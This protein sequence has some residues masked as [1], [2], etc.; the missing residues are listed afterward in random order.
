ML[1]IYCLMS[2]EDNSPVGQGT[3]SSLPPE[4]HRVALAEGPPSPAAEY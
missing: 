2:R 1:V 3:H 4:A